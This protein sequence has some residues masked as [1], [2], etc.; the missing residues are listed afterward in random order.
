MLN[1]DIDSLVFVHGYHGG[2]V[3]KD[4]VRKEIQ[5]EIQRIG[6][7]LATE[8]R[9]QEVDL[10]IEETTLETMGGVASD[11]RDLIRNGSRSRRNT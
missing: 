4:L 11:F 10:N 1:E 8:G 5:D 3:L 6:A 2:R 7:K 9:S